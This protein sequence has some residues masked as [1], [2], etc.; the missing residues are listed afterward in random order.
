[1][2]PTR[3]HEIERVYNAALQRSPGELAAFLAEACGEDA[4]LRREVEVL[5]AR[6]SDGGSTK[7]MAAPFAVSAGMEIEQYRIESKLGEGG[8]G[9]VY[10]AMDTKLNRPVA[11]KFLSGA[12]RYQ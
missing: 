5:L 8:M 7:T 1:M 4:E 12:I 9:S 6:G 10:R 2:T 11:M 3:W